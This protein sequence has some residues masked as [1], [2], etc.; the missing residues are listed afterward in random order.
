MVFL[1]S[2]HLLG[3][4]RLFRTTTYCKR[5]DDLTLGHLTLIPGPSP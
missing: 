2:I 1:Q 5:F 3:R 4:N